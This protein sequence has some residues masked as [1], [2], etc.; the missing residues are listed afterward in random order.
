MTAP[1]TEKAAPIPADIQLIAG[2]LVIPVSKTLSQEQ[3]NDLFGAI[4]KAFVADRASQ[5]ERHTPECRANMGWREERMVIIERDEDGTPTVWCDPCIA[6]LVKALNDAGIRTVASCCGHSHRPGNIA[7][8]DGRWL[9][10]AQNDE[11]WRRIEALFPIDINGD[12]RSQEERIREDERLRFEGDL[13]RW[14]KT[15][16]AGITGY[17]PEA[18]AVMDDA[19]AEL[20]RARDRI[21]ALEAEAPEGERQR[22]WQDEHRKRLTSMLRDPVNTDYLRG[23]G[24]DAAPSPQDREEQ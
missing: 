22:Q 21:A 2:T 3:C 18:Y 20:V 11:E 13:D 14:M 16:G 1:A 24:E 8:A 5:E 7:L 4:M 17:Q 9:V 15:L 12:D 19:C 23:Y 10:I 6:P